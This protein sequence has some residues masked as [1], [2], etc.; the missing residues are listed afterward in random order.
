MEGKRKHHQKDSD[1]DK[2]AKKPKIEPSKFI[3]SLVN[4]ETGKEIPLPWGKTTIIGRSKITRVKDKR[5]APDQLS[6]TVN[7]E[8]DD[9]CIATLVIPHLHSQQEWNKPINY[10][11]REH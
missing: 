9:F 5:V 1:V 10:S 11:K 3:I 2:S 7:N 4:W 6:L 8:S